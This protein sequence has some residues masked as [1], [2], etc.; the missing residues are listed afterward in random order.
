MIKKEPLFHLT[1]LD[2][3]KAI[4]A[5]GIKANEDGEIFVFTDTI[6]ADTIARD[7]VF[8]K[9]YAIFRI[10]RKG[11]SFELLPDEVAEFSAPFQRIIK[12]SRIPP[13]CLALVSER[14]TTS[15]IHCPPTL[16][17]IHLARVFEGCKTF[18]DAR[19]A[20]LE[21]KKLLRQAIVIDDVTA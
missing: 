14:E 11:I 19:G 10:Y 15:T 21:R 17:E 18:H 9:E 1:H 12:M 2:N 20:A 4:L 16:W 8:L 7:Q 13:R 6:V 5:D 3:V